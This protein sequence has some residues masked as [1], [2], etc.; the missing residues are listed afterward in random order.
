MRT[1]NIQ[2]QIEKSDICDGAKEKME[3]IIMKDE[4]KWNWKKK[5]GKMQK[6]MAVKMT[7]DTER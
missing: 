7:Q 3:K 5:M 4:K 6:K 1:K 2:R